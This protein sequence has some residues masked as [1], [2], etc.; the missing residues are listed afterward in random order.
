MTALWLPADS[1]SGAAEYYRNPHVRQ[2]MREYCGQ[3]GGAPPSAAYLVGLGPQDGLMPSW[4]QHP[5]TPPAEI[6]RLWDVG[7]DISRALWDTRDLILILDIDYQNVDQP[8]EPY[9][10]PAEVFVK[11]EPVYRTVRRVLAHHGILALPVMTG[12]GYHFVGRV[13]LASPVVA[14]LARLLPGV[15]AWYQGLERRRQP[16]VTATMTPEHASAAD[17]LGLIVEALAHDV[18]VKAQPA[19]QIPVVFNGTVV[20][21]G[22]IG[23]ECASI[24]FSYAGDPLDVRH[25]RVLFSAYQWHRIRPDLFGWDGGASK[26]PLASLP[27]GRAGLIHLLSAG[28][29]FAAA[30][31]AAVTPAPIPDVSAGLS[32]FIDRYEQSALS[33]FHRDYLARRARHTAPVPR[34]DTEE[35]PPCV[36]APLL[37]PNDLLLKPAH[38]QHVVRGCLARGWDPVDVA[39]LVKSKYEEDHGWGA[40]WSWMHAQ[41]RADFD[42]R[43]F[44][45]LIAV[46]HDSLIDF[47]CVSTQEKGV[48]PGVPCLR[49][50]RE[51]RDRL[52]TGGTP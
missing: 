44:A 52:L 29:G 49:D 23:R 32:L 17:G 27:R 6:E 38:I 22:G 7:C 18:L 41:T 13:P 10:R 31:A 9:L 8:A 12:R 3:V 20:G 14:R 46:G 51:E 21:A 19:S 42:V 40:R 26:P 37:W 16:G 39:V 30:A 43:V 24:D 35:L 48:C 11:L 33:V 4:D 50:L 1:P 5:V 28:H 2:R 25:V 47:N 15:P 45:G 36:R 34:A